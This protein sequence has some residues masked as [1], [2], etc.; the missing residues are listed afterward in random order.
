MSSTGSLKFTELRVD[1]PISQNRTVY[2]VGHRS[3]IQFTFGHVDD[4]MQTFLAPAAQWVKDGRPLRSGIIASMEP[5]SSVPGRVIAKISFDFSVAFDIGVYQ[6][7][8]YDSAKEE[9]Y[10]AGPFRV[11]AGEDILYTCTA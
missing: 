3:W 9:Y 2:G 5:A 6:C 4:T 10:V 1:N 11:D 7:I 8:L